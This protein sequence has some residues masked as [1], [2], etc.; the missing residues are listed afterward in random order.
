[1]SHFYAVIGRICGDDEDSVLTLCADSREGA[2]NEFRRWL[3]ELDG[4]SQEDIELMEANGQGVFV[5]QILVSASPITV[6]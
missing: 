1:M 6:L 5:N 4:S 3:W 2:I